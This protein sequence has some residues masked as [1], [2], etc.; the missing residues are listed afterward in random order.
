MSA[1]DKLLKSQ[2]KI[3]K[4]QMETDATVHD[5]QKKYGSRALLLSIGLGLL[6]L[7]MGHKSICR[8]LVLGG[9]FSAVNF[10]LMGQLLSYRI[11]YNRRTSALRS[12][13]ALALRFAL[14]AVPLIFAVRSVRFDFAATVV[15]IF[16]V[17]LVIMIEQGTRYFFA[18]VKH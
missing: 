4:S 2:N 3:K 6:F 17:Q 9:V 8:G 1:T 13:I 14:L 16:T 18:S 11:S 12:F 7:A 15:G 10:A 5:T